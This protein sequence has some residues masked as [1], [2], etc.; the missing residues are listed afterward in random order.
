MNIKTGVILRG[1]NVTEHKETNRGKN[2]VQIAKLPGAGEEL[3][4]N[5]EVFG[6]DG[7]VKKPLVFA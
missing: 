4:A 1:C 2:S 6:N 5:R 3:G 7:K